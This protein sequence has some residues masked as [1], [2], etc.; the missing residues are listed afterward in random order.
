MP[1]LILEYFLTDNNLYT[2][3][4]VF[5]KIGEEFFFHPLES[6]NSFL[7]FELEMLQLSGI[8]FHVQKDPEKHLNMSHHFVR[9]CFSRVSYWCGELGAHT[10]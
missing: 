3:I 9:K 10:P 6:S 7:R 4:F 1:H 8:T 5:Y 2:F